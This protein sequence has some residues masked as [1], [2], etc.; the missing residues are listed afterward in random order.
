MSNFPQ[1][2]RVSC[3]GIWIRKLGNTSSSHS[4]RNFLHQLDNFQFLPFS[5][6]GLAWTTQM[7]GMLLVNLQGDFSFLGLFV[8]DLELLKVTSMAVSLCSPRQ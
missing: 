8:L 3:D 2:Q 1:A 6:R 4:D 7:L 5:N